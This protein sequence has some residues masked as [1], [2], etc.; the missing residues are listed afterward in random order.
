VAATSSMRLLFG[1][2]MADQ[3]WEPDKVGFRVCT[4]QAST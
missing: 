4:M 2:Y 1:T 3:S